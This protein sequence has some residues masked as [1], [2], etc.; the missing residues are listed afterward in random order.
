MKLMY[1]IKMCYRKYFNKSC[2]YRF[3]DFLGVAHRS[4]LCVRYMIVFFFFPADFV[5]IFYFHI[6]RKIYRNKKKNII[7]CCHRTLCVV[8]ATARQNYRQ[9]AF[10][11]VLNAFLHYCTDLKKKIAISNKNSFTTSFHWKIKL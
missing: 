3:N 10:W 5:S 6:P 8:I 11:Y 2:A 4:V 1:V 7:N 9:L